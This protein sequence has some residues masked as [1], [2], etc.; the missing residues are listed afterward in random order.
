M[1]LGAGEGLPATMLTGRARG[2]KVS[3]P[4]HSSVSKNQFLKNGKD[5]QNA[6]FW[7]SSISHRSLGSAQPET[8]GGQRNV[9]SLTAAD[10]I[11]KM[12][13]GG[14]AG[15]APSV[16]GESAREPNGCLFN[17][18][19]HPAT[20]LGCRPGSPARAWGGGSL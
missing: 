19:F 7:D 3:L 5:D 6:L 9:S 2:E 1:G 18:Q 14:L 4:P 10:T 11:S 20:R 17:S 13:D 8:L 16:H 15:R 12:A